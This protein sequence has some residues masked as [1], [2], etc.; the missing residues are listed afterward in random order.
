MLQQAVKRCLGC[1]V[2]YEQRY[3]PP[4]ASQPDGLHS[5]CRG[6]HAEDN[7]RRRPRMPV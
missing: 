4:L 5:L 3:F 7:I 2:A 1:D 6:C